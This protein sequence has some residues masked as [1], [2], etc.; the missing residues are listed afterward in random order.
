MSNLNTAMARADEHFAAE[1]AKVA[2]VGDQLAAFVSAQQ[3]TKEFIAGRIT[4]RIAECN[5]N[6]QKKA[7]HVDG[8]IASNNEQVQAM[9]SAI[10]ALT[11]ANRSLQ[12]E[13]VAYIE[14][15]QAAKE[16]DLAELNKGM[17]A[18][19]AALAVLKA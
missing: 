1:R 9:V 13:K 11:D 18:V 10:E 7:I 15:Q 17:D 12:Q 8:Q 19:N 5:T 16:R 4:D 2:E 3:K 14:A 6:I